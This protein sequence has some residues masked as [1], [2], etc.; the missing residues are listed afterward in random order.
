MKIITALILFLSLITAA[1]C[2]DLYSNLGSSV[3]PITGPFIS[4]WKT[5]YLGVSANDQITLPLVNGGTYNCTVDWG[6]TQQSE[7][8]SWDDSDATHTYTTPGTYKVTITGII[9]GFQ[10]NNG[11]DR[12]KIV[13][14]SQWGVLNLGN[15]GNYF[16][17]CNRLRITASDILDLTGTTN[18]SGAFRMC[19]SITTIPSINNWDVS[20]VIDMSYMFFQAIQFNGNINDWDVSKV[21]NMAWMFSLAQTFNCDLNWDVSKVTDMNHMFYQANVFN[22]NIDNWNVSSVTN[23]SFMFQQTQV[24]NRNLS[25]NVSN[26]LDMS[27]MFRYANAFNGNIDNWNVSSVTNMSYMFNE[28]N[29]FNGNIDNWNVSNV[30]NTH[31]MFWSAYSFNQ[32]IGN[33]NISNVTDINSMFSLITLSTANYDALLIGW[34]ARAQSSGVTSGLTFN[35]GNSQYSAGA[36]AA[37]R[38]V[39]TGAPNNWTITDG[40]QVP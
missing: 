4:T 33:W 23:M 26:V 2:F 17:G 11:G 36:A 35:G 28:A 40:G 1:S 30:T 8:T 21:T 14:I 15:S 10:F 20:K 31:G 5:D 22:G 13:N 38:A 16:Y 18:M 34:A 27:Y 19:N 25:W 7:I 24:F 12:L 29:A 32:N 37:A 6:D 39:L 3:N 9:R